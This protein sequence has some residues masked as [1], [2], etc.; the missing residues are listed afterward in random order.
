MYSISPRQRA[1]SAFASG[2]IV[3]VTGA[4]LV[5][6]LS[7]RAPISQA[8]RESIVA[9][10]VRPPDPPRM[11]PQAQPTAT[12]KV[13][14]DKAQSSRPKNEASP[15]NLRNQASAIFAPLLPPIRQPPPVVAAPR[16]AAGDASNTGAS[17]HVGPGQG[18]GGVGN[19]NGGGGNGSGDGDGDADA[20]TRP[21]QIKGKLHWS[22]LPLELRQAHRGGELEL[23]YLVNI[24]GRVSDCRIVRSSGLPA[25]DAQTCRL[26]TERFR[27]RPSLDADG[28][29]VAQH[30]IELHGWDPAPEDVSDVGD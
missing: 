18:A 8:L 16:P 7:A 21:I 23:T 27:F 13:Q 22:D 17:S 3:L 1:A 5:F 14:A 30:I 11:P 19:G 4:V 25:L 24:D 15:A 26:I 9:L 6:G 28:H 10:S 2:A 20:V 29:P 12:A